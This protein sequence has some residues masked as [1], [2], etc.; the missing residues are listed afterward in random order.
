MEVNHKWVVLLQELLARPIQGE[1]RDALRISDVAPIGGDFSDKAGLSIKDFFPNGSKNE[2]VPILGYGRHNLMALVYARE[3]NLPIVL[4]EDSFLRAA[5]VF[6]DDTALPIMR[7]S[8]S[9]TCD[10]HGFYFDATGQSDIERMI[11]TEEIGESEREK[12]NALIKTITELKLT[13]YNNQSTICPVLQGAKSEKVLVIDQDFGDT[14][15]LLGMADESCFAEMLMAAADENPNADVLVKTHPDSLV[16]N[17]R[18][19][20]YSKLSDSDR[21]YKICFPVNPYSILEKVSKVYVATSAFGFEALLAGKPVS[22]FGMPWYAGWG[23]TDD[24]QHCPR[25]TKQRT[26]AELFYAFYVKY[27]KY[28]NPKSRKPCDISK[29]IDVLA[30]MR[31]DYWKNHIC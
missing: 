17:G 20:Y 27:T 21:I 28:A 8:V 22:V 15:T 13:K 9:L 24:R 23:V 19:G 29:A 26:L 2:V 10:T 31:T 14:S 30:Q 25:R 7:Q 3:R 18:A 16:K 4:C 12:A 5:T 11:Q 1:V 6:R